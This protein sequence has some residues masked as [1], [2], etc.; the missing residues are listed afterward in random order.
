MKNTTKVSFFE[1]V[2]NAVI[3]EIKKGNLIW[4]SRWN[5]FG[6][7]QNYATKRNYSGFN[8]FWLSHIQQLNNYKTPYWL[9]FKQVYTL[10]LKLA[11][12]FG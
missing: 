10:P 7:P 5:K 2:T 1:K 11:T 8:P 3:E 6:M 4:Q 9:T 12:K